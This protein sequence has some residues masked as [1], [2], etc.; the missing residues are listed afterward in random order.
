MK[1]KLTLEYEGNAFSGWQYQPNA[2][3]VQGELG[4]ALEVYLRSL[5]KKEG[6]FLDEIPSINGSSRTDAG[7]HARG[8]IASFSWPEMLPFDALRILSAL[9]G[10]TNCNLSIL[11]IEETDDSFDARFSPH[12]KCYTYRILMRPWSHSL[13]RGQV[14]RV[15][16]PLNVAAMIEAARLFRGTHDFT[17]FR[18]SDCTAK[19]TVRTVLLS[20]FA[21]TSP[22]HLVYV[23]QGNGFLKQMVRIIVGTLVE[24]GQGRRSSD[25]IPLLLKRKDR[26]IAG[27]TAPAEGLTLD[28]VRYGKWLP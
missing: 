17:S 19:S 28:W 26:R 12:Y 13:E 2:V 11:R 24:L 6:L 5:A 15:V 20:E 7:V 22:E 9:N 3:T 23:I 4:R 14:W 18:A 10:I 27:E 16:T 25:D 8:Q 21:R 1:I